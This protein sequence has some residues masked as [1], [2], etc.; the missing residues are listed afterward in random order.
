M[1]DVIAGGIRLSKGSDTSQVPLSSRLTFSLC[2]NGL[3]MRKLGIHAK[4]LEVRRM[5][6]RRSLGLRIDAGAG[7]PLPTT[8]IGSKVAWMGFSEQSV[9]SDRTARLTINQLLHEVLIAKSC[10]SVSFQRRS[11]Y[12]FSPNL[13]SS[14]RSLVRNIATIILER[15]CIHPKEVAK[16][17]NISRASDQR[18]GL[19]YL[20]AS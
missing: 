13:Q 4:R 16:F 10:S 1:P 8:I 18:T 7:T 11:R 14:I 2:N 5:R 3:K 20:P 19:G 9:Q 15:L 17:S 12:T 6:E